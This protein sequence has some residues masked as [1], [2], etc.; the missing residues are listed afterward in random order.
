MARPKLK[1]RADGRYRCAYKGKAFYGNTQ[2]EAYRKRDEYRRMIEA[3]LRREA[4]GLTVHDYAMQWVQT[5]KAHLPDASYNQYVRI[6]NRFCEFDDLGSLRMADI[7]T[8]D[9]QRFF[10]TASHMSQSYISDMHNTICGLFRYAAAD[11]VILADPTIKAKAPKGVKGTHRAITAAERELIDRVPHRIRPAVMVMLYAGLRRGEVLALD[12]DRDVDFIN[13][14]ISV[15]GAVIF[16]NQG[17][18]VE[19][20]TKTEAG[21]RTVPLVQR[22]ADELTGLHGRLATT[23]D[24]KPMTEISWQRAWDSY[25]NALSETHNG[26]SRRWYGRTREHKK[27]IA[28]YEQLVAEG[29]MI[30]AEQIKLPPWEDISI[31]PHDLRHSYCTM[32]YDAGI[33]VKTAQK[34]MGHA[35]PTVT[36][37]IY[38]HLTEEREKVSAEALESA[39]KPLLEGQNEGQNNV[40]RLQ[41]LMPQGIE[42]A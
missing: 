15:R 5:Y 41:T 24:G 8:L 42:N 23:V 37:K 4:D 12:I 19:T 30:E 16:D 39:L 28:R 38:T 29:R 10:N 20:T 9:V 1:Q 3:G 14:T 22:L 6:L 13:R 35:D 18:P 40:M 33:D 11:R 26:G 7:T 17:Q 36:M 21:L 25:I 34:W 27:R 32:L 2:A 31:R